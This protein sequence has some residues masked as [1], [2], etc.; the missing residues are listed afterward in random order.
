M[1]ITNKI[2]KFIRPQM[3]TTV[4]SK[5]CSEDHWWS[6]RL[7]EVI[8]ESLCKSIFCPLRT[9]KWSA[10]QKSLG[11]TALECH[12]L[13]EWTLSNMNG[14]ENG[15][16]YWALFKQFENLSLITNETKLVRKNAMMSITNLPKGLNLKKNI[17]RQP[18]NK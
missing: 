7:A 5:V 11:T 15:M 8:R 3:V 10:N 13:F 16:W 2:C 4:I 9:T 12:V 6:A 14:N 18:R 1:T 17:P